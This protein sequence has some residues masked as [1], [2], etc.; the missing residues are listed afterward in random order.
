MGQRRAPVQKYHAKTIPWKV[1]GLAWEAYAKKYG[2]QQSPERMA[3]RGGFGIYEMD[4]FLPGWREM[5]EAIDSE[6]AAVDTLR[7]QLEAA[8]ER[9][10]T[11]AEECERLA[12]A[13]IAYSQQ[14]NELIG[15]AGNAE[16]R[17]EAAEAECAR[18]RSAGTL[19]ANCAFNLAQR[20]HLT[21]DERRSLDESRI[22]W[23]AARTKEDKK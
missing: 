22:A 14:V 1:H 2:T 4:M 20:E 19:L 7:A 23:D 17:A 10:E 15:R 13:N 5:A 8:E 12:R 6:Q 3:E 9:A 16:A 11:E 18:L 21:T